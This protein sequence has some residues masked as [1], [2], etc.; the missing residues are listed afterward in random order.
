M[1]VNIYDTILKNMYDTITE[2][3]LS[4]CLY[5]YFQDKQKE[6]CKHSGPQPVPTIWPMI[7]GAFSQLAAAE[8]SYASFLYLSPKWFGRR[9]VSSLFFFT[10]S[11]YYYD[12]FEITELSMLF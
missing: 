5:M 12:M 1:Y 2:L 9:D 8:K 7:L 10:D 6:L 4:A 3:N 11:Y